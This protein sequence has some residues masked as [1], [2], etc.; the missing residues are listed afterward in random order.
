M[1]TDQDTPP[2]EVDHHL[3]TT[4]ETQ[5]GGHGGE[6]PSGCFSGS[7]GSGDEESPG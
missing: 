7:E 6:Y 1:N 3:D 5:K 4:P 2:T